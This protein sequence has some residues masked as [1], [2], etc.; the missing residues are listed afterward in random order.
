MCDNTAAISHIN[1]MGWQK[2]EDCNSLAKEIW[3]WCIERDLWI[4]AAHIPGCNNGEKGTRGCYRIAT[5]SCCLEKYHKDILHLR[6]E[7]FASRIN[8][9]P[10]KFVSWHP[11]PEMWPRC[12]FCGMEEIYF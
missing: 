2:S 4:S 9:Q 7:Q 11:E 12:I 10:P 5:Q 8:K 1:H 6:L 3:E